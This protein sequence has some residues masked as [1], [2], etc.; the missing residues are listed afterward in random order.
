MTQ[1]FLSAYSFTDPD[2]PLNVVLCDGWNVCV[3]SKS[4]SEQNGIIF[5]VFDDK[6]LKQQMAMMVLD[7]SSWSAETVLSAF[8]VLGARSNQLD[9]QR[10]EK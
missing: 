10:N 9:V 8:D 6:S 5:K 7:C 2:L 1:P 4:R 3:Y